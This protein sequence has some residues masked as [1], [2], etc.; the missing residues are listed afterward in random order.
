MSRL[1][2]E[3]APGALAAKAQLIPKGQDMEG[4][5]S[6]NAAGLAHA[7]GRSALAALSPN[8]RHFLPVRAT[9]EPPYGEPRTAARSSASGPGPG[10]VSPGPGTPP[11]PSPPSPAIG[12]GPGFP[13]LTS[14]GGGAGGNRGPGGSGGGGG[15][16]SGGPGGLPSFPS[17]SSQP[18]WLPAGWTVDRVLYTLLGIGGALLAWNFYQ[19][20]KKARAPHSGAKDAKFASGAKD[21]KYTTEETAKDTSH[22]IKGWFKGAK[23]STEDT[24]K[25]AEHAVK[26][27]TKD[28]A[29]TAEDKSKDATHA[30][31]SGGKDAK[32][33]AE[34]TAKDTSHGAKG[35]FKDTKH[36]AE[37]GT[38]DTKHAVESTAK[39]VKHAA[40]IGA[41][42]AAKDAK[43]LAEDVAKDTKHAAKSA[44]R[45]AEELVEEAEH[46][47]KSGVRR[48]LEGVKDVAVSAGSALRWGSSKAESKTVRAVDKVESGLTTS[49]TDKQTAKK[50]AI[51]T[52]AGIGLA[53]AVVGGAWFWD[54]KGRP[55]GKDIA[56]G[57]QDNLRAAGSKIAPEPAGP[58]PPT[59]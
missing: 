45:G 54:K 20:A 16:G 4:W 57:I 50:A 46:A 30:V 24:A 5:A 19:D 35:W 59:V 18:P 2:L 48:T 1:A 58:K 27:G 36:A 52:T 37:E 10:P 23:R 34:D 33:A 40:K 25:D 42:A 14:F 56:K 38:K 6:A 3:G 51:Y 44:A 11:P 49:S 41:K 17:G 43:H 7:V 21:V 31:K 47:T 15:G 39:D 22:G 8:G 26:S 55:S 32:H 9:F 28:A 13:T 12:S 29:Y 53:A